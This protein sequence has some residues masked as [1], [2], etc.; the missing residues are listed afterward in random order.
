MKATVAEH[1]ADA[2]L[3]LS[4]LDSGLLRL[5]L[6]NPKRRNALSAAMLDRLQEAVD[7]AADNETVSCVIIA[8]RGPVF[9][10]GHDLKELREHRLDRD[11]G[12][13]F[14]TAIM[15]RCSQLMQ[16]LVLMPKPVIAE[17]QGLASAAGLQLAASC[18]FIVAARS[19]GFCTPGV[20]I[21]L[22]CST[23]M[24]ALTRAVPSRHALEMLLTGDVY[25]AEDAYRFGLV[26]RVVA[27]N[28]LQEETEELARKLMAKSLGAIAIG[29]RAFAAQ[30][31]LS[32][33]HAY[34]HCSKV[35]VDNLM[36]DEADAGIGAF[37]E[38]RRPRW[39]GR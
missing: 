12:R 20:N 28:R 4:D 31:R 35:M 7:T 11:E 9:S 6:N 36:S 10:S 33:D 14:F 17:V 2:H 18:D 27:D 38:K 21:G 24:V 30:Q 34:A 8:G 3:V 25:P 39:P 23:P 22:F 19:A 29:K 5:T 26:N 16:S 32:L 1:D 13:E 37:L 15:A